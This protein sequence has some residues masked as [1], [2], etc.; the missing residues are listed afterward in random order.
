MATFVSLAHVVIALVRPNL[1]VRLCNPDVRDEPVIR[2]LDKPRG[3]W[4]QR[5][6]SEGVDGMEVVVMRAAPSGFL[7]N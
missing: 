2:S 7:T 1:P 4:G 5:A 6:L 3:L